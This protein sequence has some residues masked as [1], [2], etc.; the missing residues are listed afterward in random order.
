MKKLLSVLLVAIMM[1]GLP[2]VSLAKGKGKKGGH[3]VHGKVTQ[4]TDNSITLAEGKKKGGKTKTISVPAGT[5]IKGPGGS[6]ATLSSLVGKKVTVK[7]RSAGTAS[8]I[9]VKA[10]KGKKKKK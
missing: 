2:S 1:L 5:P 10:G 9:V 8:E 6:T 4:T 7:E 3:T